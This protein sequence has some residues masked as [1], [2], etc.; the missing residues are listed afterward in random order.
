M[1]KNTHILLSTFI[2]LALII[3]VVGVTQVLAADSDDFV[4]TVKTDNPGASGDT[5]FVIGTVSGETYNYNVDCDD[6]GTNETTG[7]TGN[8]T[9]D[10]SGAGAGTYTIRIKD[11]TEGAGTGFP[12]P[13]FDQDAEKL[14]TIEQWG[15]GKW[16]S[17]NRAFSGCSNLTVQAL[18][19][20]DLSGVTDMSSMFEGASAF[21]Q[22]IESWVTT[23]VTNMA[24]IFL[25]A[26]SFNQPIE[27]WDTSN[28]TNMSNMFGG[29]SAFNQPLNSGNWNTT[30]VETMSY[31]FEGA[32]A[33]DQP[34]GNWNT[35]KVTDMS[36]MFSATGTFNQ[37]VGSWDT[38]N[39]TDMSYMFSGD[40][41]F[42]QN[43]SNWNVEKVTNANAMFAELALSRANYDALLESWGAQTLQ[44]GV[45]FNGGDST[46]CSGETTRGIMTTTYGWVIT[47][48][49]KDCSTQTGPDYLI[50]TADDSD[51][52]AC[53]IQAT[54]SGNQDCT[55]RE[56]ITLANR[57]PSI[58]ST[59][60][61]SSNYTISLGS[62]LPQITS[63]I[64]IDGSEQ[65]ATIDGAD[66]YRIFDIGSTGDLNIS[67]LTLQNGLGT[68]TGGGAI[69]INLGDVTISDSTFTNNTS[70]GDG[71]AIY[72][73]SGTLSVINSTFSNN[74]A[75]NFG[76]GIMIEGGT[77]TVINSTISEN[78]AN[79]NG[80]GIYN[81]GVL[82]LKNTILANSTSGEDCYNSSGDTIA[83]NANN[84]IE[85]NGTSGHM[86]GTPTSS[87]APMLAPLANNGGTT[88][89]FALLAESPAVDAG[90]DTVCADPSTVNNLDQRGRT[91]SS[92]SH[93][94]IGAFEADYSAPTVIS[95]NRADSDPTSATIVNFTVT[96]SKDVYNV[97]LDDFSLT[98]SGALTGETLSEITGLGTTYTVSAET[99]TNDGT[100]RLDLIDDDS[101]LDGSNNPLGG[102]NAG[103]G[104]YSSGQF[105]TIDRT[106]APDNDLFNKAKAVNALSYKH[107]LDTSTAT[108]SND[109]PNLDDCDIDESAGTVWYTY[110]PSQN[111]AI[112][113]DTIGS[114]YD[115]FIAVWV[116]TAGGL[117]LIAC[118]DDIND[119]DSAQ[120]SLAI[121]V[122]KDTTY[123]IE[124]GNPAVP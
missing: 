92:G 31:M 112:A 1:Q 22:P 106:L 99:G 91:R 68:G 56:A 66:F 90:N 105:Y 36:G 121:Q 103:N 33:F 48:A 9:C 11:N 55:L 122:T 84:L 32:E 118:N 116:N 98:T 14:L 82:H 46:Y 38:T 37:D 62:A 96:F 109:D 114:D 51:D 124:I 65:P 100:L 74:S 97:G 86:C 72:N 2:L 6:D 60:I 44:S 59:L 120:S 54:G 67:E 88:Q 35:A 95:I 28:V 111:T 15:T 8:Y 107:K 119:I 102:V 27:N 21:N 63:T 53:D 77:V 113:I 89:T 42:N 75:T 26:E 81:Q 29:A 87:A 94:D 70:D 4:I 85:T 12:Q 17:M 30:N 25:D 34:I 13:N 16:T 110:T 20:P 80:G 49:G 69:F 108:S 45:T 50:N 123:Y 64:D 5:Q 76:G 10:Y 57:K 115:T 23:N 40:T 73:Q 83:T 39:V 52:G 101:I 71:G 61:F 104:D 93:C 117:S 43:L 41:N 3:S 7:E 79:T 19:S 18:D 47:D 78:S 24:G 58:A